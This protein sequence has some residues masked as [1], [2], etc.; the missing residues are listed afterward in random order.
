MNEFLDNTP[1]RHLIP[2]ILLAGLLLLAYMVLRDENSIISESDLS[3]G[4]TT[5]LEK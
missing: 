5:A 4:S 2:G 3:F 1:L